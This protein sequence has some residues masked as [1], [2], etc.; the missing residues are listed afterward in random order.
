MAAS[1]CGFML[2]SQSAQAEVDAW[3]R[4]ERK[5]NGSS[6]SS[7]SSTGS[8]TAGLLLRT[9]RRAFSGSVGSAVAIITNFPLGTF[10]ASAFISATLP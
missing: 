6:G 9:Y 1:I 7:P 8:G 2:L 4:S 5:V 10:S 3:S